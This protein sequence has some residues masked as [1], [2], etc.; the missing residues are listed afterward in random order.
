MN[1]WDEAKLCSSP[2]RNEQRMHAPHDGFEW[3][4]LRNR[5]LVFFFFPLPSLPMESRVLLLLVIGLA[6]LTPV[7][8]ARSN[9]I[10]DS[11]DA[12]PMPQP[13][14]RELSL[15]QPY[16]NGTDVVILQWLVNRSPYVQGN[17][18]K[19]GSYDPVTAAAVKAFQGGN[20]LYVIYSLKSARELFPLRWIHLT[21]CDQTSVQQRECLIL[22]PPTFSFSSTPMTATRT[23]E[24]SSQDSSTR[25][26]FRFQRI[27][28]SNHSHRSMIA[29][30]I[31]YCN[32]ACASR[33]SSTR[34]AIHWINLLVQEQHQQGMMMM[35]MKS[36]LFSPSCSLRYLFSII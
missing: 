7:A 25:S 9:A 15:Q 2:R 20:N 19:D 24:P 10:I 29:H 35:K 17:L 18:T 28:R 30:S 6:C 34:T 1:K 33:A 14:T 4:L 16:L 32:S 22:R 3:R 31:C 12:T 8:L 23:T 21:S 36:F 27:D 13:W 26:I 11:L 5:S